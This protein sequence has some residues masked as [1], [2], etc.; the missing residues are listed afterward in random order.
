MH[1]TRVVCTLRVA[2]NNA[3]GWN[4]MLTY[5]SLRSY[6]TLSGFLVW[7][8]PGMPH[9]RPEDDSART[10]STSILVGH[11]VICSRRERD[12]RPKTLREGET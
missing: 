5:L 7:L 4:M 2:M 11:P 12:P 3:S 9:G 1:A 10:P 6:G 8:I